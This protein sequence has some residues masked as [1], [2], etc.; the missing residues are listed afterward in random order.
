M[1]IMS[2]STRDTSIGRFYG[3][4]AARQTDALLPRFRRCGH[5]V[6]YIDS[7]P[8]QTMA[9]LRN[10]TSR[11]SEKAQKTGSDAWHCMFD[12]YVLRSCRRRTCETESDI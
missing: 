4:F 2:L 5:C 7:E 12:S 8:Q 1:T 6:G 11:A 9:E 3:E 10:P